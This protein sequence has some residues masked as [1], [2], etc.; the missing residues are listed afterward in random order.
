MNG[1]HNRHHLIIWVFCWLVAIDW[2]LHEALEGMIAIKGALN[3]Q[4][5]FFLFFVVGI[6]IY[7]YLWGSVIINS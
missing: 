4:I 1:C 6:K 7:T 2:T 3:L 5:H